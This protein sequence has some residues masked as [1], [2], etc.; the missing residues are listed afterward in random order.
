MIDRLILN[1]RRIQSMKD[2]LSK[3]ITIPDTLYKTSKGEKQKN[4][5]S[6]SQMRVPLGVIG[7]IYESRPNVT[8]DIA[9]L[10]IKSGNS[11]ILRGGKECINTNIFL[12]KII[13]DS[14]EI[15]GFDKNYV[16]LIQSTDRSLVKEML[17]LENFIDYMIPRGSEDLVKFVSEN[18]KM[19]A[20]TGGVGVYRTI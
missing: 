17:S 15:L 3:I 7:I 2:G 1:D 18:A 20:V 13:Q 14:I 10:C 9:S 8:I 4:G 12:H 16:Q 11:T 6:V 5:I 19:P